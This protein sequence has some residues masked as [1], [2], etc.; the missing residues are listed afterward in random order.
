MISSEGQVTEKPMAGV[1]L[2]IVIPAFNEELNVCPVVDELVDVLAANPTSPTYEIILVDD[3]S[4]DGTLAEFKKL[5]SKYDSVKVVGHPV[6]K[7]FGAALRTG[8]AA[9]RGEFVTLTTSDGE[10]DPKEVLQLFV[11]I[12]DADL[13]LSR[14]ERSPQVT[15]SSRS[16]LSAGFQ[17]CSRFLLGFDPSEIMGVYVIRREV[18]RRLDL[19][20]NTGMMNIELQMMCFAAGCRVRYGTLSVR[21]RLSGDSKVTNLPTLVKT[22]YEMIKLRYRSRR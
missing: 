2:S 13:M 12:G 21:L 19:R 14:R 3:G 11:D 16:L 9:S 6:N 4:T 1:V 18:L 5:E 8:Y 20:S 17:A 22:L 15:L 10:F 7:G